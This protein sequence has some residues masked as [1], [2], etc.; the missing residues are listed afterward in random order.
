MRDMSVAEVIFF[1][2][3]FWNRG[4]ADVIHNGVD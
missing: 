4:V 2:K 1:V 3:H